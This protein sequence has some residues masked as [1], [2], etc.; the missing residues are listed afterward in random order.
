MSSSGLYYSGR[1]QGGKRRKQ[2]DRQI[3]GFRLRT[4][5]K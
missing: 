1:S 2:N 4:K 3:L 5:K